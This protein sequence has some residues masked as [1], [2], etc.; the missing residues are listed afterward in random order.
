MGM[1]VRRAIHFTQRFGIA[2]AH[3]ATTFTVGVLSPRRRYL[4]ARLARE[5]GYREGPAPELPVVEIAE[6]TKPLTPV[7]LPHPV[8]RDGNVTLL[9][10]TV[11]ARL[12]RERAPEVI[13]EIGTFDGRTTSALAANAPGAAR[14]H[15]LDL[16]PDHATRFAVEKSERQFID[17][18]A[19]GILVRDQPFADRVEQLYGDS[20]TFDFSGYQ[21]ELVFVDGS[22]AYDY[23]INDSM[24]AFGMASERPALVV[25]H[26]YGE[27]PGVT[28]ALNEL[29]A[30][31]KEF[32]G[33]KHVRGTT[34][35]VLEVRV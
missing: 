1:I 20:A 23:V 30:S 22:H 6:I 14:I 13:F 19:S 10:L 21:P 8:E 25:W 5:A 11:L 33:L 27:W 26:D 32:A 16:P 9:E 15:T 2:L 17:K 31:K 24:K 4:I 34:L 18:P 35:A 28:Q 7:V 12:V 3:V 29:R